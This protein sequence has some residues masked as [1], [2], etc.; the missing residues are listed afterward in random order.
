MTKNC[1]NIWNYSQ[2]DFYSFSESS[3]GLAHL[4]LDFGR[5]YKKVYDVFAGCGVIGLEFCQFSKT[6]KELVAIELQ[7]EYKAHFESN[8]KKLQELGK[9]T[10]VSFFEG[11]FSTY[12]KDEKFDLLFANPPFFDPNSSRLS[13][14][15]KRSLAKFFLVDDILSFA[16]FCKEKVQPG[17]DI[18]LL[19]PE[20]TFQNYAIVFEELMPFK[21]IKKSKLSGA[22]AFVLRVLHSK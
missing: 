3:T 4:A 13:K 8:N 21:L 20:D 15:K 12:Q 14:N 7:A 18:Y 1:K 16:Y 22:S 10:R 2:P 19:L 6:C 9:G 11:A 5:A 17:G